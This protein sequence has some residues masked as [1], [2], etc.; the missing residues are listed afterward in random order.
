MKPT[1]LTE[2][3]RLR[4]ACGMAP[5][6][7]AVLVTA[8]WVWVGL[9]GFEADLHTYA[10]AVRRAKIPVHEKERMLDVIER[11]EDRV[12]NGERCNWLHW[13][14]HDRTIRE[15]LQQGIDGEEGRLIERELLRAERDFKEQ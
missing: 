15:M 6:I 2:R 4:L 10:K 12:Q 13:W 8:T 7:V 11:L 3:S 9:T 5:A 1:A 14:R